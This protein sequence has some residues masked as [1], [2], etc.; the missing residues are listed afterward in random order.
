ME[1]DR[2]CADEMESVRSESGA[3]WYAVWLSPYKI[4]GLNIERNVCHVTRS[5]ILDNEIIVRHA[6]AKAALQCITLARAR[7]FRI[8]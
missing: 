3:D 8:T 2:Q 4:K 6:R 1:P 5:I 7:I